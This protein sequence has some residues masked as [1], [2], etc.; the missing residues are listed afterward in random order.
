MLGI[1]GIDIKATK[2]ILLYHV[3]ILIIFGLIY[4]TIDFKKH[5]NCPDKK[6]NALTPLYFAVTA[7]TTTGYGDITATSN[8]ARTLVMTHMLLAWMFPLILMFN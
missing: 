3:V 6:P 7:H 1:N 8:T 5:F 4:S 2:Y